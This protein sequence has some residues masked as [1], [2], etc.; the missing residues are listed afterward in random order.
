M[1]SWLPNLG[2]DGQSQVLLHIAYGD[3]GGEAASLAIWQDGKLLGE[4]VPAAP[5]GRWSLA[6]TLAPGALLAAV[7][8]QADGDY[9]ITS[10]LQVLRPAEAG[11]GG[12]EEGGTKP[13]G[14]ESQAPGAPQ[15][16]YDQ[17]GDLPATV[18]TLEPTY[19][20]AGGPPGSVAQAK[21]AGRWRKT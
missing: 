7:A 9:A 12:P 4:Q 1:G 8:T 2:G 17:H 21:L 11:S 6:V 3:L 10:P 5:D 19:G 14:P 20:Q 16:A 13:H 18:A 15:P